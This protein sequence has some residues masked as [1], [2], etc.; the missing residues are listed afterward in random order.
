MTAL[1]RRVVDEPDA[2]HRV[3]SSLLTVKPHRV[4]GKVSAGLRGHDME[5]ASH[6]RDHV[7]VAAPTGGQP[8]GEAVWG[9][10]TRRSGACVTE[11]TNAE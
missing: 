4:G 10:C 11:G 8:R 1:R 7:A 6:R 5:E 9:R 3:L 2:F